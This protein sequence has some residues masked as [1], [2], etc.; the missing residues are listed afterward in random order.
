M[1]EPC[2][3][4]QPNHKTKLQWVLPTLFTRS[5][6]VKVVVVVEPFTWCA[7]PLLALTA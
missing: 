6:V 1:D 4:I 7:E 2:E 5:R 3:N